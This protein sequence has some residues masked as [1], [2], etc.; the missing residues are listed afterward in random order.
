MCL[1]VSKHASSMH[2]SMVPASQVRATI[3]GREKIKSKG[4]K[5]VGWMGICDD[6]NVGGNVELS[7]W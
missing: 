2:R 4:L 3:Y 5:I 1:S 7:I 6:W